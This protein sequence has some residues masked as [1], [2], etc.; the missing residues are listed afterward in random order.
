[1][2]ARH[3]YALSRLSGGD[4]AL[5]DA[6][7]IRVSGD[8][9]SIRVSVVRSP[10]GCRVTRWGRGTWDAMHCNA[11]RDET[12]RARDSAGAGAG[13]GRHRHACTVG[14]AQTRTRHRFPFPHPKLL[15]AECLHT[16]RGVDCTF[17]GTTC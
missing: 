10:S 3:D 12:W 8:A 14:V 4:D 16:H 9:L 15:N 13:A 2:Q 1:M 5:G 17:G 11:R 7:S 6:L